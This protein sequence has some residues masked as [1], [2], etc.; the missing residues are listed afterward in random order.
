MLPDTQA[1]GDSDPR[2][3]PDES[4]DVEQNSVKFEG[5][6]NARAGVDTEKQSCCMCPALA[7]YTCPAC[8]K[9][10]CSVSCVRTH[11]EQYSCTGKKVFEASFVPL[12]KFDENDVQQGENNWH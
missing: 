4:N 9:R 12:S 7:K 11:K 1:N 6:E 2:N 3:H 8:S 10:T 5:A